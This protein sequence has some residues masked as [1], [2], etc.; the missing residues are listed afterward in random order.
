MGTVLVTGA[1]GPLGAALLRQLLERGVPARGMARGAR[2]ADLAV[3]WARA[4]LLSGDGLD[5]ALQGV[6]T[7]V[8][9]AS[10]PRSRQDDLLAVD[11]LLAALKKTGQARLLYVSI[12]GIDLAAAALPYYAIKLEVERRI[13][14]SDLP[15]AIVRVAQ[16]HPF[17]ALILS[18]LDL[19]LAVIAP[20]RI[21]L[22]PVSLEFAAERLAAHASSGAVGRLPDVHG[23]EPLDF[24]ELATQ[25]VRARGRRTPVLQ[26]PLPVPPFSALARLLEANGEAGGQRWSDW[27]TSHSLS[28]NPYLQRGT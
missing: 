1:S 26:L 18:K 13:A 9:C 25:W 16:F 23:P 22:Q 4:D 6:G 5:R 11:Q 10:N 24:R 27:L 17:V 20:S 19:R 15:H 2:P 7:V 8:H 3:D 14:A 28:S 21:V 12:A